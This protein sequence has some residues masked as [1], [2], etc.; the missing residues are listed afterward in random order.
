M[1]INNIIKKNFDLTPY[2]T[3]RIGGLAEFFT[4]VKNEPELIAA[5]DWAKAKKIPLHILSGG[6]NILIVRKKVKGLVIKISGERHAIKK[7]QISCWAGA[8]LTRLSVAAAKAGLSSLEWAYGI[9]GTVGGAVRG[10]AGAFGADISGNFLKAKAYDLAS[11]KI[12]KLSKRECDFSYRGSMFK[13]NNNLII[14]EIDLK[15]K[16]GETSE[17]K[18]IMDENL[19]RRLKIQPR[20]PS[21]GC[22]FKNLL[23]QE[24]LAQNKS[25]A[26]ELEEQGLVR[27]GK[28]ASGCLIDRLGLKGEIKGGAKISDLHANFIINTGQA[29]AKDVVFL[30]NTAKKKV[31]SSYKIILHEEVQYFGE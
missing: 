12:I 24:V 3:F 22:V 31:K 14:L 7:N 26:H 11:G 20:Q 6:S 23:F 4:I 21:A 28:I 8:N 5:A 17:I 30:I 9:P 16:P 2:T 10:N 18:K 15:V 29:S 19:K 1:A 25:L 13:K 27:G